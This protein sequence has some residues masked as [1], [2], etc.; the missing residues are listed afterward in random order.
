VVRYRLP[1]A[2]PGL[3]LSA[4][5]FAST[6]HNLSGDPARGLV[7]LQEAREMA[8]ARGPAGGRALV[9]AVAERA[10]L[11]TRQGRWLEADVAHAEAVEVATRFGG[12]D[13]RTAL[14]TMINRARFL[15]DTGRIAEGTQ[16]WRRLQR[17]MQQR[18]PPLED[19]WLIYARGLMGSLDLDRGRPDLLEA[20]LR[21]NIAWLRRAVPRSHVLAGRLRLLSELQIAQGRLDEAEAALDEAETLWAEVTAGLGRPGLDN[22]LQRTRAGLE[23]ARGDAQGAL[24]RLQALPRS[25]ELDAGA[26]D[27][28]ALK[29]LLLRSAALRALGRADEAVRAARLAAAEADRLP[30][31]MRWPAE[32]ADTALA[33]GLS[34]LQAGQHAPAV[35]ELRRAVALRRAFDLPGSLWRIRAEAALQA[36]SSVG[37]RPE[38]PR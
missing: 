31:P 26:V 3:R 5:Y 20:A 24:Q 23:L 34:L 27:R 36:A 6:L 35:G 8:Q 16:E 25:P 28:Q 19:W 15:I 37:Q 18:Q 4:L 14:V 33:L 10:D 21:P 9:T 30:K 1:G 17:V 32:E 38:A 2:D 29:A 22:A 13:H 7:H 11:L 12:P